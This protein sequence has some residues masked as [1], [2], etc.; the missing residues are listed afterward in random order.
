MTDQDDKSNRARQ[1]GIYAT[2]PFVLAVPPII[3]WLIG[4]WLD[5]ILGTSP[6]LRYI[7]L[8]LGF[9]AGFREIYRLVK[10]YGS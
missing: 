8:V 7:L 2:V 5:G 10:K 3:G 6:F 1:V 4:S 9:V